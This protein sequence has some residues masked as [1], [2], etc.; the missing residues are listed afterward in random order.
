MSFADPRGSAARRF[1]LILLLVI[2]SALISTHRGLT[3]SLVKVTTLNG[4]EATDSVA[5]SQ[6]GPDG[7]ALSATINATS[8]GAIAVTGM[9]AAAGSL[10]SVVC[11]AAPCSWGSPGDAGFEAGD[12]VIWTSDT[13]NGGTGPLKLAFNTS[14]RGVGAMIQAD[15]PGQFTAQIEAFNGNTSLG[16]FTATSDTSGDAVF[17]GVLDNS[18]AQITSVTYSLTSCSDI[19]S[20][21]A[22]DTLSIN[23]EPPPTGTPTATA[24]P[25]GPTAVPTTSMLAVPAQISFGNADATGSS[26]AH[27]VRI[28]NKGAVAGIIGT[29]GVSSGFSIVP[30]TDACSNHTVLPKKSCTM[31][32]RF[33]PSAP[34]PFSGSVSVPYNGAAP[35]TVGLAGN[36]TAVSLKVPASV[37][38]A[39]VAARSTGA[40]KRITISNRS[41]AATIQMGIAHLGGPFVVASDTCS[42][43]SIGPKG[44][45]VIGL[46][47]QAPP[48]AT[49]KSKI[50]GTLSLGFTY[51]TNDG[52]APTIA[53]TGKVK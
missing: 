37:V 26:K 36:G 7:T 2:G 42:N 27:K 20:D 44:K 13:A 18:A 1:V 21:F 6:L 3:D 29:A 48:G 47:F 39:P 32:L 46:Q 28:A 40:S 12:T 24:T 4:L 49:S 15:G 17:L 16:S 10:A 35:A 9:L 34:G 33:A 50:P 41:K 8:A 11:P 45:C 52:A 14:V 30:G 31:T 25:P 53:L 5:W 51:G 22:I 23:S 38:F 19:C 43:Q